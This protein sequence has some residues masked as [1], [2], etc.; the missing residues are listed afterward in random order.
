MS[1]LPALDPSI[2]VQE[3][4]NVPYTKRKRQW[5]EG[6]GLQFDPFQYLDSGADPHLPEYLI[7]HGAFGALW[8]DWSSFLFAPPGGG[9]TAFRVLVARAC[10]IGMEGR[11]I[12]PILFRPP[13]PAREGEIPEEEAIF[14]TLFRE[15]GAE[16][17]FQLAYQPYRLLELPGDLQ[18]EI[19]LLLRTNLPSLDYYIL[20]L[21]DA[22][23]LE[24]L[25]EA[26]DPTA[27]GLP[28][29]PAPSSILHLCDVLS[30]NGSQPRPTKS[31]EERLSALTTVIFQILKYESIYLLVDGADAYTQE[32][33]AI[34][35]LSEPL[36]IRQR[37]WESSKIFSKF[38]L[39]DDV[40]PLIQQNFPQLLTEPTKRAIIQW[41]QESLA[42][43]IQERLYVASEGMYGSLEAIST[44][45]VP[46][47]AEAVLAQATTPP[48]PREM[49][50]LAQRIFTEH[51]QRVG[52]YGWLDKQDF[53][54][55]L[56]WY[57]ERKHH[58]LPT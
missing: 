29:E 3:G 2:T 38:F 34:L 33:S 35:R 22:G 37:T 54:A 7:D 48:V 42:A 31:H 57:Q 49:V 20:Q 17:L 40:F 51:L 53:E 15:A 30:E 4:S 8:G 6:L 18:R 13:R 47:P 27:R 46:H 9:K 50:L 55:A 36:F 24:P 28:L 21:K 32:P 25:A 10:R 19:R 41:D 5:L 58:A 14:T 56:R 44:R 11:R 45:E 26:F 39:P 16:L 52:P 12:F 1:V 43:V 23:S